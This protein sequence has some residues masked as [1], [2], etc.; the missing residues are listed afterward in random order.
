MSCHGDRRRQIPLEAAVTLFP[1]IHVCTWAHNY[2]H[3]VLTANPIPAFCAL[4]VLMIE[5]ENLYSTAK[6]LESLC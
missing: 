2:T 6:G 3:N 1:T 4:K 5:N